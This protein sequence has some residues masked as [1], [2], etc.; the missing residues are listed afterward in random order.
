MKLDADL[1]KYASEMIAALHRRPEMFIGDLADERAATILDG[2]LW[3]A[4]SFWAAI[5]SREQDLNA[6]RDLVRRKYKCS[7]LPFAEF[8][9][10]N[11]AHVD[12]VAAVAYVLQCWSEID[13]QLGI[14]LE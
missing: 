1:C 6:A 14:E 3:M 2:M 12:E 8:F 4:H 7:G 10:S 5:E 13:A 11:H 9:R